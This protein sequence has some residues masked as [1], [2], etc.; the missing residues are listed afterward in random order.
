MDLAGFILYARLKIAVCAHVGVYRC[1]RTELL[2][3]LEKEE[4]TIGDRCYVGD[5]NLALLPYS[6]LGG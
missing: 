2:F 4:V 3:Y 5:R 6:I 1:L